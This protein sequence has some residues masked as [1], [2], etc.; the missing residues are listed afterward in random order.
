MLGK[1]VVMGGRK[2]QTAEKIEK[3]FWFCDCFIY[4]KDGAF[5]AV[6]REAKF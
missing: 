2:A 6:K 5:T 3:T 1:S 4:F